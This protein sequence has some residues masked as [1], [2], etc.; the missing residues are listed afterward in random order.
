MADGGVQ[1]IGGGGAI[2]WLILLAVLGLWMLGAYNRL[3]SLRAAILTAWAPMD[4]TLGLR[5]EAVQALLTAGQQP[6]ADEPAALDAV[7]S[8]LAQVSQAAELV[9][10]RPVLA[11]SVSELA[12]A[13]AVLFAVS[14]RLWA[15]AEL[16]PQLRSDPVVQEALGVLREQ[17]QHQ[18][19]ARQAFNDAV[20]RYNQA[21]AEF[22]TRLLGPVFRF[23]PAGK[24]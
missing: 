12:R 7:A 3:T 17:R 13:D 1:G 9:R 6:L 22:P 20:G 21:L 14:Q 16:H 2:I 15:L 10:K 23:E 19:F 18:Q 11:D 4:R 5:A 24:L 8:A